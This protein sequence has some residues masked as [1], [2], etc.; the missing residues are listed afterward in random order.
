[1]QEGRRASSGQ[2]LVAIQLALAGKGPVRPP[3]QMI[4]VLEVV[5]FPDQVG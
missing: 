2:I 3:V 5:R 1:M 4:P